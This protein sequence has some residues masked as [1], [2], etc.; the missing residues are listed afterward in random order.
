MS[1]LFQ[2]FTQYRKVFNDAVVNDGELAGAI[3]V[4]VGVAVGWTTVSGPTSVANSSV[5]RR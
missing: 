2:L 1:G 4:W 5:G 3:N